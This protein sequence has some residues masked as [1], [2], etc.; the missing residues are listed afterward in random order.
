MTREL[1]ELERKLAE[2]R[3]QHEKPAPAPKNTGREMAVGMRILM[4]LIGVTLGSGLIGYGLD[5][6][7][8]TSPMLLILFV[9]LGIVAAIFNIY[10]IT[11]NL[12]TAIGSHDLHKNEKDV[13]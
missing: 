2:A 12:G 6:F 5:R 3:A 7:F 4:E 8:E 13:T 9:V 10:K 11:R 1:D